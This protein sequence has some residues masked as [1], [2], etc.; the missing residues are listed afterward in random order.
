MVV[1]AT[2]LVLYI[3]YVS[4]RIEQQSNRDEAQTADVILVLGAAE[5]RG[6]PSRSC[7]PGWTMLSTCTMSTWRR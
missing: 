1:A 4:M 7:A 3:A 5:Y 6:R 2:A